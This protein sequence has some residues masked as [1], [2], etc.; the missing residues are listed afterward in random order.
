[1]RREAQT[2]DGKTARCGAYMNAKQIFPLAGLAVIWGV[3]YVAS[4]QAVSEISVFTVGI[5]IRLL[6]LVLLSVIMRS[7]GELSRLFQTKGVRGRLCL[8][9]LMGFLL[10][11]TAFVGLQISSSGSGT[12]LL[13]TDILFVNLI[14]VLI[15]K[16]RFRRR[17]WLYTLCMLFGVLL[18]MGLDPRELSLSDP[19]G[20]FFLLS[21]LFV[22]INAFLIKSVQRSPK[23]S[24]GSHTIAFYNNLIT[25][26]LFTVTAAAMGALPQLA[27]I[28]SRPGL[29]LSL[30]V[31]GCGQTGIYLVYYYDLARFPVW[32]VKVFLLLMPVVAGGISFLL[33]GERLAAWQIG[34]MLIVLL[35]ACGI[36]SEQRAKEESELAAQM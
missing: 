13:K 10:D 16:Q 4:G 18:V 30:V 19:G 26:A 12:A 29:L 31:A 5:V 11:F 34:G 9:G 25:L 1:M 2:H 36:L 21:A 24:V 14:S 35:G 23:G 33:F 7:T 15:Y 8:I 22:S 28:P 3:Y 17:E 20:P 32:L 27:L 6:T